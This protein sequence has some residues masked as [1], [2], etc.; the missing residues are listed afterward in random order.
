MRVHADHRRIAYC[1]LFPE[2]TPGGDVNVFVFNEGARTFWHRHQYQTD[3]FFVAKGL[4]S[5]RTSLGPGQP[6]T[7]HYLSD[8]DSLT[9][10]PG[11]YHGYECLMHETVLVMYLDQHYDPSDEERLEEGAIV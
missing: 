4:L 6:S 3:R 11:L 7:D 8:G 10:L 9:I 1:D 5:V 2:G